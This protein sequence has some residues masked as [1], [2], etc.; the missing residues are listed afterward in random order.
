MR[1]ARCLIYS[2]QKYTMTS[3]GPS[4]N[5]VRT[6]FAETYRDRPDIV[7]IA[8]RA[9]IPKTVPAGWLPVIISNWPIKENH[10]MHLRYPDLVALGYNNFLMAAGDAMILRYS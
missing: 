7:A 9:I 8:P 6:Y 1:E 10:P 4:I 2:D 3:D 5:K